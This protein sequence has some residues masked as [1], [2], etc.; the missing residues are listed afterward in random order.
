M[1]DPAVR[2]R[3]GDRARSLAERHPQTVSFEAI[4][5]LYFEAAAARRSAAC[6]R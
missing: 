3:M 2:E 4:E 6:R 5:R 1:L